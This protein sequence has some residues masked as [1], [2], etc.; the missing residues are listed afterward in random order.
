MSER[1][2]RFF[3]TGRFIAWMTVAIVIW[4]A[5][6]TLLPAAW[7]FDQYPFIFLTLVLS[8][9]ASYAAPLILLAQNRQDDR[10]RQRSELDLATDTEALGLVRAIAVHFGIVRP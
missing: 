2:A 1:I 7:R 8:L 9:Q 10:D 5:W 4:V 6:N 3:G